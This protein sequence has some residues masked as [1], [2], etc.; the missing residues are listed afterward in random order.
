LPKVTD[1]GVTFKSED[2]ETPVAF[3]A[4]ITGELGALLL[5]ISFPLAAPVAAA[6]KVVETFAL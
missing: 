2:L 6:V 1:D 3:K 4:T 5:I